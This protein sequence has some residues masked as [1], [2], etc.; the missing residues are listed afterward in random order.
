MTVGLANSYAAWRYRYPNDV[1]DAIRVRDPLTTRA[2]RLD[3]VLSR[4]DGDRLPID[5]A[6]VASHDVR[7]ADSA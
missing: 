2:S 6:G 7:Q 1:R 3:L 4:H 5:G